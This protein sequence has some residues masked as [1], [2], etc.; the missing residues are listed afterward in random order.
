[1]KKIDFFKVEGDNINRFR[2][3]CPKCGPGIFLAEHKDRF[4]CGNCGYTEFKSGGKKEKIKP[5][6]MEKPVEE[7]KAPEPSQEPEKPE[8][9]SE[10]SQE[11]VEPEEKQEKDE[12]SE[13][14]QPKSEAAEEE[15]KQESD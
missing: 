8:T 9:N 6:P 2:K 14:D 1:M 4:S 3:H 13:E 12:S 15:P 11:I 10:D 5:E 7:P